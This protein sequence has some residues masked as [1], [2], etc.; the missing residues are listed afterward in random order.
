MNETTHSSND[1]A[2]SLHQ[3][4]SNMTKHTNKQTNIKKILNIRTYKDTNIQKYKH[5]KIQTHKHST[6]KNVTNIQTER[7]KLKQDKHRIIKITNTLIH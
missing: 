5:T 2:L 4:Q 3:M 1:S 6:D 7:N